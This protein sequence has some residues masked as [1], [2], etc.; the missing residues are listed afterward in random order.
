MIRDAFP[1]PLHR[2]E[3]YTSAESTSL[4]HA[5]ALTIAP[6]AL[7]WM[8]HTHTPRCLHIFDRV[9]NLINEYG[10]V[11]S[12]VASEIGNG[13][14]NIVI[15]DP[16]PSS[17][18]EDD[19]TAP[20]T[21]TRDRLTFG[22][23]SIDLRNSIIWLPKPDWET[24]HKNRARVIG[25]VLD[26][27]QRIRERAK[28]DSLLRA[29]LRPLNEKGA[30]S[31][32]PLKFWIGS[33]CAAVANADVESCAAVARRVAGLGAGLTPAGDDLIL[34]AIYAAW[35]IHPPER[36]EALA[37]AMVK[38]AFRRTTSLSAAWLSAGSR[39]EAGIAWHRFLHSLLIADMAVLRGSAD[40][41]LEIGHTSGADAL[42]GFVGSLIC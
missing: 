9:F 25:Q 33:L 20:I 15:A 28:P 11:L 19:V 23:T 18:R 36:A 5:R 1:V 32:D 39:G 26:F 40:R 6:A 4:G 27:Q 10:E 21:I 14:F 38:S 37:G 17:M 34:G 8:S 13:P 30:S 2:M 41:L 3:P 31:S 24:L 16:Y 22:A 12:V 42:A 7:A 35:V 29:P